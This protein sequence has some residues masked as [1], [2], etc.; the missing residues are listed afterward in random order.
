MKK[1]IGIALLGYIAYILY[2]IDKALIES[3]WEGQPS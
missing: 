2:R 1:V 3:E